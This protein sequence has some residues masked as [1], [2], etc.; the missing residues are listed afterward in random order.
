MKKLFFLSMMLTVVLAAQAQ[1]KVAPK[2]QMGDQK[3]YTSS[4]TVTIPG[5]GAVTINEESSYSVD[6]VLADGFVL[7]ME[8]TK[9]TSDVSADNI[10]GQILVAAQE[11]TTG[12]KI[13]IN[14]DKEGKPLAI[15]N[16]DEVKKH[17][18]SK[19]D[20]LIEK[21]MKASPQV[22]QVMSKEAMKNQ[23][24]SNLTQENLMLSLQGNTNVLALN[25]K[26]VMT[27]AQ[28]EYVNEEGIKMKRMYFV[29][30]KNVTSNGSVNMNKDELKAF[31]IAQVEKSAPEQAEMIKQNIDQVIGSGMVKLE[32]K[33]TA[34]YEVGDDGWVKSIKGETTTDTMGQQLKVVSTVTQ[35]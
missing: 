29:N 22:A 30:G 4:S 16:Y 11:M 32:V 34:T 28:E 15:A 31:I 24:M 12:V 20:V 17:A 23:I 7:S 25:G 18:D 10:A 8:T 33:E 35:K 13:K 5:Q 26:T 2:M 14:V 9:M 3:N 6:E 21:V 1:L 19:C 27:G